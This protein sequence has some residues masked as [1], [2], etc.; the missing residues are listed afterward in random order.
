MHRLVILPK[1]WI[2][3]RIIRQMNLGLQ[4]IHRVVRAIGVKRFGNMPL[5]RITTRWILIAP[6][7]SHTQTG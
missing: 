2:V 5:R 1:R 3:K 7:A 4:I 6:A